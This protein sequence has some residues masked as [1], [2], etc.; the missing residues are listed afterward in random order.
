VTP[1]D[2]GEYTCA[3]GDK[4]TAAKVTVEELA[5]EITKPLEET[6]SVPEGNE[7]TLEAEVSKDAPVTWMKNGKKLKPSNNVKIEEDGL[8]RR[9]ILKD[10]SQ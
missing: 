8:T 1:E 9:L 10:V 2:A 3:I 7:V 6:V 4:E 5:P